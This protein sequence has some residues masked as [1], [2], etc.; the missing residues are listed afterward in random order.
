MNIVNNLFGTNF[1]SGVELAILFVSLL[2]ILVLCVWLIRRLFG[3]KVARLSAKKR[4]PRL[5]VT[6]AAVVDDKR[7]LVLVRRDDVEHLIL[8]GGQSDVLLE[9]NISRVKP[10]ITSA[11][12]TAPTTSQNTASSAAVSAVAKSPTVSSSAA[13]KEANKQAP[14][15]STKPSELSKGVGVTVGAVSAIAVDAKA[16]VSEKT[17]E[18]VTD[19]EDS[20]S[21]SLNAQMEKASAPIKDSVEAL[22]EGLEK[23]ISKDKTQKASELEIDSETKKI[24]DELSK[25][26]N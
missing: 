21:T 10:I 11:T 5:A 23:A 18:A 26:N 4:Q 1:N 22:S 24:L 15:I 13:S 20:L 12:S 6:D 7:R 16:S 8:I 3:N 9:A 19:T 17:S 25:N 14:A 2:I